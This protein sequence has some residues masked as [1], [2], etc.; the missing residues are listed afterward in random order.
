VA[1]TADERS[2]ARS[3]ARPRIEGDREAEILDATLE[4]LATT[5]YER[6]TMDAVAAAAKASKATLYRRW[7]TK[8]ELV[9]DAIG[10]AKNAP[11]V[12]DLDTGSLRSDLL[13]SACH[14]GGISDPSA[15]SVLAGIIPALHHDEEFADAFRER[16][17]K[18][19]LAEARVIYERA[20]TRGEI[21]DDVD[22]ELLATVLPAIALHRAFVLRGS[23]DDATV[24][25]IIDEVVIPASTRR[26]PH[27]AGGSAVIDTE[28]TTRSTARARP[29]PDRQESQ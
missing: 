5:G 18:P 25:R 3:V 6:L 4:L 20:R 2:T 11:T 28:T 27:V 15:V 21:A 16:F 17:L 7:S 24:A 13:A 14:R 19:K 10:R 9:I 12:I 26:S 22:L 8:A 23:V 29:Q 1:T